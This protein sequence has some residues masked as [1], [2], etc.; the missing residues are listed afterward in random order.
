[1]GR[2]R[3]DLDVVE[4]AAVEV[5]LQELLAALQQH[6][7]HY[8]PGVEPEQHLLWRAGKWGNTHTAREE[9]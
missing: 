4:A 9:R 5:H 2:G 3:R 6:L 7:P 1:M 8:K